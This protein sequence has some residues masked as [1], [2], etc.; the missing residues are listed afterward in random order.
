[1]KRTGHV[2]KFKRSKACVG[3][4]PD[5]TTDDCDLDD[6]LDDLVADT[7]RFVRFIQDQTQGNALNAH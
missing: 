3:F 7:H 2:G 4:T 1:M 6:D 5:Y